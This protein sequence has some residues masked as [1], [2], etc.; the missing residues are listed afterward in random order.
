M[1][2]NKTAAEMLLKLAQD[3]EKEAA[4]KTIFAC[5]GCGGSHSMAAINGAIAKFAEEN[6]DMDTS[7]AK[8]TVNDT[9]SCPNCGHDMEYAPTADS[10]QYYVPEESEGDEDDKSE[11][12][13]EKE[14]KEEGEQEKD[15]ALNMDKVT[16]MLSQVG[17]PVLDQV[18]ALL[19]KEQQSGT[20]ATDSALTPDKHQGV[21]FSL[22]NDP[23]F[24]LSPAERQQAEQLGAKLKSAADFEDHEAAGFG[25]I[26]AKVIFAVLMAATLAAAGGNKHHASSLMEKALQNASHF[27]DQQAGKNTL[28]DHSYTQMKIDPNTGDTTHTVHALGTPDSTSTGPSTAMAPH[29]ASVEAIVK[30]ASADPKVN[31]EKLSRYLA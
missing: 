25:A 13:E 3:L 5:S 15:A 26:S 9:V 20:P 21:D 16:K 18:T 12:K 27:V 1:S 17:K 2:T 14:E 19:K 7:G 30:K 22:D 31:L 24:H 10:E 8:I 23:A 6:P 11:K 29:K 28:P 4:E